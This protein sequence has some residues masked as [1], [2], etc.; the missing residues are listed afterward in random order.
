MMNL[1]AESARAPSAFFV[2]GLVLPSQAFCRRRNA[3][4]EGERRLLLAILEDAI[5][6]FCKDSLRRSKTNHEAEEWLFSD[7]RSWYFAFA[8]IC[9]ILELDI[10]A[11][12]RVLCEWRVRRLGR[13]A[14]GRR[15][16]ATP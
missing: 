16:A 11:V 12:R 8:N 9:D 3:Q 1:E 14:G 5:Q 2:D 10:A 7:D 4:W 13:A 15:S 6:S